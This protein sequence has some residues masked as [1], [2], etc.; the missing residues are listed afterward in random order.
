VTAHSST[1]GDLKAMRKRQSCHKLV[2]GNWNVTSLT[3]KEHKRFEEA[4]RYFLDAVGILSI[5]VLTL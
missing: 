1:L 3:G 4:E 5:V 2:N